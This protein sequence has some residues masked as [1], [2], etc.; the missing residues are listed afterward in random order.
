MRILKNS[1]V[2]LIFRADLLREAIRN[3]KSS[4]H[5]MATIIG[6]T[7]KSFTAKM[8]G[9]SDWKLLE[10]QKIQSA[11]PNLDVNQIFNL[12]KV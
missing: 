2:G 8:N 10:I 6:I 5:K 7:D 12:K 3:A 4:Q 1:D 11:I 9:Y